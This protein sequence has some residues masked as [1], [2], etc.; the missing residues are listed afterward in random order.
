MAD[1]QFGNIENL[2]DPR[3]M[4]G[5]MLISLGVST[6]EAIKHFFSENTDDDALLEQILVE[7]DKRIARRS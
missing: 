6:V 7:C 1:F 4:L 2:G 3:I 5:F